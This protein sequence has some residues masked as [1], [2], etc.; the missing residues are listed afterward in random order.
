MM[1]RG[2]LWEPSER[3][4]CDHWKGT[5]GGVAQELLDGTDPGDGVEV[6]DSGA[7]DVF[8]RQSVQK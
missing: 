4:R 6:A 2:R 5:V 7:H 3:V 1:G 8:G